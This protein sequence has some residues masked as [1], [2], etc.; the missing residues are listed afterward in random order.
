MMQIVEQTYAEK[1]AMYM[2]CSKEKLAEMLIESN[3]L[4]DYYTKKY[5][6]PEYGN[7]KI[8]NLTPEVNFD[9][10]HRNPIK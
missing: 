4:L 2:K 9:S 7:T 10:Y 8:T 6:L 3:R 5:S 1:K